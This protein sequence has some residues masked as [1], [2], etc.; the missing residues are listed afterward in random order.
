MYVSSTCTNKQTPPTPAQHKVFL[1]HADKEVEA[2][3]DK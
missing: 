3:I 1:R 2:Y